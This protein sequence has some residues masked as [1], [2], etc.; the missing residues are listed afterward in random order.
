MEKEMEMGDPSL[1]CSPFLKGAKLGLGRFFFFSLLMVDEASARQY[2]TRRG[3]KGAGVFA[4]WN[5]TRRTVGLLARSLSSTSPSQPTC[6]GC[7]LQVGP[8]QIG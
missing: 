8:F 2:R 1:A 7:P 6:T 5:I 3:V 4:T